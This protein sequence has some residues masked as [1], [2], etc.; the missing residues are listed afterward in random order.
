MIAAVVVLA[1]VGSLLAMAEASMSRMSRVRALALVE[2]GRRNAALLERIEQD[3]A[4]YL[5][6]IYLAVMFAQN[7][8]AILVAIVAERLYGELGITLISIGFTLI[9]FLV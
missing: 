3:P 1:L 4:R 5:N 2:E 6:S 8:S 7:G 9:Y